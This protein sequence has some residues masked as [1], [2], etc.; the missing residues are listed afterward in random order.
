MADD[1]SIILDMPFDETEGS[2]VAYD[3]SKNRADGTVIDSKFAAEGK[4][5]NCIEFDGKGYCQ[6]PQNIIPVTGNFTLFAWIRKSFPDGFT[7]RQIG[8][9]IAWNAINGYRE[10][11]FNISTD[12]NY[13]TIVKNGL[14]LR[15]YL[16]TQLIENI[17][18]TVQPTGISLLQDIYSTSYGYGLVDEIKAYS[19]ALSQE[20]INSMLDSVAQLNYT[21]NGK[22]LLKEWGITVSESNGLLD[23]PKLKPPFKLEWPDY[24]G[25]VIDLSRKRIEAREIEL[26]CWMKAS[27]K[28][29]FV[30]KLN[31]FLDIFQADGTQR[32]TV[33]IHPT[34][35]LLYEVY[36]EAGINIEKRWNDKLMIGTFSLKLIEP[37]PVKRV[38]RHQRISE[39]TKTLTVTLTSDK[40]A[41]IYWGDGQKDEI[42]GTGVTVSHN[43]VQEG[44][45]YAII[46]GVIEEIT[47]FQTNGII[48]WSKL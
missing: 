39:A 12:W 19:V 24:H 37:D 34:K 30:T 5:G 43:Y 18:L 1:N 36:N 8:L 3:Y 13:F 47:D 4:Q 48:V 17:N 22:D 40:T 44:I 7:G 14:N 11:W 16:D 28:I 10:S 6:I 23:R 25:Q 41:L 32:L 26:N 27:G 9:F 31:N 29:D 38:V 45:F 15:L 42:Y 46:A 2:Q 33:N 35:P 21:I 20:E